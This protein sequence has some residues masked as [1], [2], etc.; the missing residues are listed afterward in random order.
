[1]KGVCELLPLY[2]LLDGIGSYVFVVYSD[3][4]DISVKVP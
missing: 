4:C 1:V 2:V 3:K